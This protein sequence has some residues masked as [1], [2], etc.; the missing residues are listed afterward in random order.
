[1][2]KDVARRLADTIDNLALA[3]IA[4]GGPTSSGMS[5]DAS[6]VFKRPK[7]ASRR[8]EVEEARETTSA[9]EEA[10]AVA[11]Q[12]AFRGHVAR[13][14]VRAEI[15]AGILKPSRAQTSYTHASGRH[16]TFSPKIDDG[17]EG[18][19]GG[20][21]GV[22]KQARAAVREVGR[23]RASPRQ[24]FPRKGGVRKHRWL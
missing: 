7:P 2:L 22:E 18:G 12:S 20:A 21:R 8:I 3:Q 11:V 1:M 24:V 23:S 6:P 10:A 9:E 19:A 4:A 5:R 16:I 13:K 14:G 15:N 17:G